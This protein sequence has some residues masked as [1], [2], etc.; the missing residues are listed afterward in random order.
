[1]TQRLPEPTIEQ[2]ITYVCTTYAGYADFL[3][4]VIHQGRI[5]GGYYQ[6]DVDDPTDCGC[7]Y[8]NLA[9][10]T[11]MTRDGYFYITYY[12]G[13]RMQQEVVH[14]IYGKHADAYEIVTPVERL[15]ATVDADDTVEN[16]EQLSRLHELLWPY[17]SREVQQECLTQLAEIEQ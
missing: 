1:M 4:Q 16:S 17:L 8:G 14:A 12:D 3:H 6:I 9:K 10:F 2:E 7:F 5:D 11:G 13:Q 15:I